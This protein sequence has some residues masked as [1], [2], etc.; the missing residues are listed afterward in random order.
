MKQFGQSVLVTASAATAAAAAITAATAVAAAATIVV[1]LEAA[2]IA[3]AAV[4]FAATAAVAATAATTVAATAAATEAAA[5]RTIFFGTGFVDDQLQTIDGVAVEH[6]NGA[7]GLFVAGHFHKAEAFGT[8]GIAFGDDLRESNATR[9][10]EEFTQFAVTEAVGQFAH[11][12]SL[13]HTRIY[14]RSKLSVRLVQND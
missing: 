14:T 2:I 6:R 1:T 3:R 13:S 5:T 4:A 7:I 11:K 10:R 12:Q 8:T 9:L